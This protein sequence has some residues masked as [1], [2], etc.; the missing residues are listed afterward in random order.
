MRVR[1]S[2]YRCIGIVVAAA[3]IPSFNACVGT[4]LDHSERRRCAGKSVSVSVRSDERIDKTGI[5]LLTEKDHCRKNERKEIPH[6]DHHNCF[7]VK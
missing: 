1:E 4:E 3:R 7:A 5:V 6:T 2:Q